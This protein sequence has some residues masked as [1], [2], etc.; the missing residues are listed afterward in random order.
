MSLYYFLS[1]CNWLEKLL[2]ISQLV[3]KNYQYNTTSLHSTK[4][5]DLYL[6]LCIY[7]PHVILS[8]TTKKGT[9]INL[10][11]SCKIS[12]APKNN[13]QLKPYPNNCKGFRTTHFSRDTQPLYCSA[14][15]EFLNSLWGLGTE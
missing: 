3:A 9:S 8:V 10:S 11:D 5:A 12:K 6:S 1:A 13:K 15:L 4:Q 14:E 7:N 2:I